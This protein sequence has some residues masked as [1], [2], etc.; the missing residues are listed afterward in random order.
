MDK[1]TLDKLKS[2]ADLMS[3]GSSKTFLYKE[4]CKQID[5]AEAKP[6]IFIRKVKFIRAEQVTKDWEE[7]VD[8]NGEKFIGL[9]NDFKCYDEEGNIYY[10]NKHEFLSNYAPYN[11]V[12]W[13]IVSDWK[14]KQLKKKE[15]ILKGTEKEKD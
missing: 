11:C 9:R 3:D 14:D 2:Y 12:A 4:I 6:G 7:F 13:E 10:I 15:E 5:L 1:K 8:R